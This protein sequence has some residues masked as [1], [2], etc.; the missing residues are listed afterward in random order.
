MLL[1]QRIGALWGRRVEAA[2]GLILVAIG[3]RILVEHLME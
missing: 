2:G 3:L 1:G